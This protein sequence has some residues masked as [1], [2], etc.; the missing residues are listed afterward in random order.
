[1]KLRS[2]RPR[3]MKYVAAAVVVV[4]ALAACSDDDNGGSDSGSADETT[5]TTGPAVE[6]DLTVFAAASLTDAFT[7]LGDAFEDANPGVTVE[8]N[9]AGSSALREQI[10]AGAPADV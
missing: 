8:F 6:G 5:T 2:M 3:S 10:I 4:M 7:E 1:M 9:F